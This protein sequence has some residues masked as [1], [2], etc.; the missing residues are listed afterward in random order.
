MAPF[1]FTKV[2]LRQ[3]HVAI[4]TRLV[5][6]RPLLSYLGYILAMLGRAQLQFA[7]A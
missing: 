2:V 5:I 3:L 1:I 6:A 7:V 4:T